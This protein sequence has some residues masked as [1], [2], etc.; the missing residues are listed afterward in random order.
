MHIFWIALVPAWWPAY[1]L[2]GALADCAAQALLSLVPMHTCSAT[3]RQAWALALREAIMTSWHAM[4][5]RRGVV[6]GDR[7]EEGSDPELFNLRR[8]TSRDEGAGSAQSPM[9]RTSSSRGA[10]GPG[11]DTPQGNLPPHLLA[12][13]PSGKVTSHSLLSGSIPHRLSSSAIPPQNVCPTG[14]AMLKASGKYLLTRMLLCRQQVR[15]R[16]RLSRRALQL[17]P[18][19]QNGPPSL[20]GQPAANLEFRL[21]TSF[22]GPQSVRSY[23]LCLPIHSLWLH[24]YCLPS[25]T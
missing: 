19:P 4:Q 11:S 12:Q 16:A 18:S 23:L 24:V 21:P 1:M 17:A 13:H 20:A 22:S 15:P 2:C 7:W 5:S 14:V 8:K 6:Q 3:H 10:P 25:N 9:Q